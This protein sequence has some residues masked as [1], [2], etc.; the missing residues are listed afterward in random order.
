MEPGQVQVMEPV[1]ERELRLKTGWAY[2]VKWDG[3]RMLSF[4]HPHQVQLQT[5]GGRVRR[6]Q[7]QELYALTSLTVDKPIILDGE[8]VALHRGRAEFTL[9]LKRNWGNHDHIPIWYMIFDIL[10]YQGE[11][12]RQRPLAERQEIIDS[13]KLPGPGF[14]PVENF[15][16]GGALLSKTKE[17]NWEGIVAKDLNSPYVPGKSPYWEKLKNILQEKLVVV[18]YIEKDGQLASLLL[19][20]DFGHSLQYAGAVG[21]GFTSNQRRALLGVLPQ[22]KLEVPSLKGLKK[23]PGWHWLKPLLQAEVQFSEW[24]PELVVRAPVFKSLWMGE[25][26]IELS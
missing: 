2:Q 19:A 16:D 9:I 3:I 6:E 18:G 11:D 12:L 24:T 8:L 5:K 4:I 13:L 10:M 17:L 23:K 1:L 26:R 14:V 25:R 21:S 7:F 15:T 22:M 20:K